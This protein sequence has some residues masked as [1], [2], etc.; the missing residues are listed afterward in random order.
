MIMKM[1]MALLAATAA[2]VVW[3]APSQAAE[4]IK[5]AHWYDKSVLGA[6]DK[7]EPGGLQPCTDNCSIPAQM[8]ANGPVVLGF[9]GNNQ[10]QNAIFGRNFI[11]PDTMGAVGGTQYMVTT[12]GSYGI[13]DKYTGAQQSLVSD[14]AF[15]AAAGQTGTNGDTRIMYNADAGRWVM[16]AFGANTADLQIAVSNTDNALG[17]WQSVKF[18]GFAGGTADY[19]TLALDKNAVYIGT[20]N[21][22]S[23][24][25]GTTLNVIPI[26]SLFGAGAPTVANMKQFVTPYPGTFEDRGYAIQGVNST[27]E[28]SSGLAFSASLYNYDTLTYSVD[29]ISSTSATGATRGAVTYLNE[30]GY[31]GAGPARQP[32]TNPN[33]R[34]IIDTLDDRVSSSVYEANG[35]VFAVH[36]VNPTGDAA[37]DYARVRVLVMR[38]SDMSLVDEYDIGTGPYDYYQG[39]IAVNADGHIVI[40]FNRSGLN[41][42]DGTIQFKAIVFT[43]DANGQLHQHGGEYLLKESLTNDYHNGAVEN[44]TATGRQRWG[45]Y[46]QVSVDPTDPNRFYLIGEWA[47]EYN[48]P[49]NGHPG[50]TGASRWSTWIAVVDTAYVPEPSTWLMLI[51][52]FGMIGGAMR[53]KVQTTGVTYA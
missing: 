15:W 1:K 41:P 8:T 25:Q 37:G 19:P 5:W 7:S 10:Y 39:S 45:D 36:T 50:G 26:D 16:V 31:V 12:N 2:A 52:G 29:N 35:Y 32:T 44:G 33:N 49:A 14:V 13:Y 23:T 27:S 53:R 24:F 46:S 21:F 3:G 42:E 47:R 20:N 18:T 6:T 34:R 17:G 38:A 40:G 28:G 22:T 48:T 43:A 4:T 30:D 51:L 11:P 9:E